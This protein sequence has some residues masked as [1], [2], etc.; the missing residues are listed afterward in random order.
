MERNLRKERTGLVVSNKMDKSIT[1]QT[2]STPY[3]WAIKATSI[4]FVIYISFKA[5]VLIFPYQF[6]RTYRKGAPPQ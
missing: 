3:F 4:L 1:A 5:I 2:R 6:Y